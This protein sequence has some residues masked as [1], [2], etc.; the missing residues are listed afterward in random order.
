[1]D[2]VVLWPG[3]GLGHHQL[4]GIVVVSGEEEMEIRVGKSYA[5]DGTEMLL[6]VFALEA[7]VPSTKYVSVYIA[8]HEC[9]IH[10]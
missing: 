1:M 2:D 4:L 6:F 9:F 5:L 8:V 3:Q 7:Y 10:V